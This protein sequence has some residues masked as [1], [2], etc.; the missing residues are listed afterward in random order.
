MSK[1]YL[2]T[3]LVFIMCI[4]AT[5]QTIPYKRYTS[6]D[7]LANSCIYRICQDD[8]GFL[9]MTTNYGVVRFDGFH[10]ENFYPDNL[11]TSTYGITADTGGSI[12]V[13][14]MDNIIHCIGADTTLY[15]LPGRS[16]HFSSL[17]EFMASSPNGDVWILYDDNTLGR[18]KLK[19]YKGVDV[20]NDT[21]KLLKANYVYADASKQLCLATDEGVYALDSNGIFVKYIKG[22][23]KAVYR[24]TQS[25]SGVYYCAG[26]GVVY[27]YSE[28]TLDSVVLPI[29]SEPGSIAVTSNNK[30]WLTFDDFPGFYCVYKGQFQN[31]ASYADLENVFVSTL[32]ADK[33][34][35][36]FL[37]TYNKGLYVLSNTE[38][39]HYDEQSG[40]NTNNIFSIAQNG[41]KE[42]YF[43]GY[44]GISLF[45]GNTFRSIKN[46]ELSLYERVN[47]ILLEKD[48]MWIATPYHIFRYNSNTG[49]LWENQ[50]GATSLAVDKNGNVLGGSYNDVFIFSAQSDLADTPLYKVPGLSGSRIEKVLCANDGSLWFAGN[51]IVVHQKDSFK[52]YTAANSPV[53]GLVK[54][55]CED[56]DHNIWF[57][58][59]NGLWMYDK[60]GVWHSYTTADGLPAS[61]CTKLCFRDNVLW[62]GTMRGVC[63]FNGKEFRQY[64]A[65]YG[66]PA[67][68]VLSLYSDDESN[69]WICMGNGL[70]KCP[71]ESVRYYTSQLRVIINAV[72]AGGENKS[73]RSDI[74]LPYADNSFSVDYVAIEYNRQ[75]G[76]EYEYRI[77]NT[78]DIWHQTKGRSLEFS[79]LSPGNYILEIRVRDKSVE[80][81]SESSVLHITILKPFWKQWWFIVCCAILVI[82]VTVLLVQRR[83]WTIKK[84]EK[85]KARHYAKLLKLKQQATNALVSPHFI[86][87]SLNS[88]QNYINKADKLSANKYLTRFSKLI[89]ATMENA[90]KLNVLLSEE[91]QIIELYLSLEQIRLE[92]KLTYRIFVDNSIKP[93]NILIPAMLIQPYIENAVWHGI[94][95]KDGAGHI[96]VMVLLYN[97]THLYIT[98]EDDGIGY[99]ENKADNE[100]TDKPHGMAINKQ[101]LAVIRRVTGKTVKAKVHTLYDDNNNRTGTKVALLVPFKL[102]NNV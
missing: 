58:G 51:S 92:E 38:L 76:I 52:S 75:E 99:R 39:F 21:G 24:I 90:V 6:Q 35:N 11:Q 8:N 31:Y 56:A 88:I 37:G 3:V 70:Y 2:I 97:E 66:L 46:I 20:T 1:C 65:A 15:V 16:G 55:M 62:I 41:K 78:E 95:P 81:V 40:L 22:F 91:V 43:G 85:R 48:N 23:N 87:N 63:S 69:L 9:W 29:K 94:S 74:V 33:K 44:G 83:V 25:P 50:F 80:Y 54:D 12:W 30:L 45:D 10:F 32:Y 5:A 7:G 89:R 60:S 14:D 27:T 79:S 101:R 53:N 59:K 86:F 102:L 100:H 17:P 72:H 49:L 84:K 73:A 34:D 19:Q 67:E 77:A 4:S 96:S 13:G 18:I 68:E 61:N 57:A 82:I 93:D 47:D 26:I 64:R 36:L 98:I 71:Q 28:G 42:M